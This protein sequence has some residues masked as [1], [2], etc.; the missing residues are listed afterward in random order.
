MPS[1]TYQPQYQQIQPEPAKKMYPQ[2]QVGTQ[3]QPPAYKP[4]YAQVDATKPKQINPSPILPQQK[5]QP[6]NYQVKPIETTTYLPQA[7]IKYQP[8]NYQNQNSDY[9][10]KTIKKSDMRELLRGIKK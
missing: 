10:G 4:I 1:P 9:A 8:I 5:Y 2:T 3:Y 7:N 6:V